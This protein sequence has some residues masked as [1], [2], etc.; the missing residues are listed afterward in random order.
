MFFTTTKA[1]KEHRT[2]V[3]GEGVTVTPAQVAFRAQA[4]RQ[5][6]GSQLNGVVVKRIIDIKIL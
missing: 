1:V 6:P 5:A 3:G 2:L 4:L